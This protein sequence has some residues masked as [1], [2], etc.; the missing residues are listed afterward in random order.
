M[1]PFVEPVDDGSNTAFLNQASCCFPERFSIDALFFSVTGTDVPKRPLYWQG[2]TARLFAQYA[3]TGR[4]IGRPGHG[5]LSGIPFILEDKE[6][7]AEGSSQI[8]LT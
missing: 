1:W 7:S 8:W 2:K 5:R 3:R 6:E 4:G